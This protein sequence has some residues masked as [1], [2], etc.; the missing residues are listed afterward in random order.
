MNDAQLQRLK[1]ELAIALNQ[2]PKDDLEV[3]HQNVLITGA[4]GFVGKWLLASWVTAREEFGVKGHLTCLSRY[5]SSYPESLRR[6]ASRAGVEFRFMDVRSLPTQSDL[7]AVHWLIHAATPTTLGLSP[8]AL[9]ETVTNILDGQRAVIDF[10]SKNHITRVLF[11]SSGAVYGAQPFENDGYSE[12][13]S[14]GPNP[15]NPLTGYH[16]A[17][18][19]AE[20]F[21]AIA[22]MDCGPEFVSARLFAFIAPLLPLDA[23]FAAGN[24]IRDVLLEQDIQLTGTGQSLRSYQYGTDLTTWLWTIL[25]RGRNLRAYNVGSNEAIS[26]ESLAHLIARSSGK[27]VRVVKSDVSLRNQESRYTPKI[28]RAHRELKLRNFVSLASAIE[29]TL[30]WWAIK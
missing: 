17:K 3:F 15:L 28:E 25:K 4:S 6:D 26:I 7:Q 11:L 5:P 8:A 12:D 27:N 13:D 10:S 2:M 21:G 23:H 29:R 16:E 9:M 22:A 19:L 24:F 1:S 18:R 30:S 14:V 20:T